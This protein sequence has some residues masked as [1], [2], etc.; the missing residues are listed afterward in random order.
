MIKFSS[1]FCGELP[2]RQGIFSPTSFQGV[3]ESYAR[4][5]GVSSIIILNKI[6]KIQGTLGHMLMDRTPRLPATGHGSS[7]FSP[8]CARNG[9]VS[10]SE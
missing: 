4:D 5:S 3:K 1:S 9:A 10:S 8:P 7:F 2:H 6:G